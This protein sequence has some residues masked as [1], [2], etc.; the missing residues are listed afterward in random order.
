MSVEFIGGGVDGHGFDVTL[1]EAKG[2][3][4]RWVKT[5]GKGKFDYYFPSTMGRE[6]VFTF[7]DKETAALFRL[8]FSE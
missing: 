3:C 6:I 8:F 5:N 1:P 7:S 4:L 2:E